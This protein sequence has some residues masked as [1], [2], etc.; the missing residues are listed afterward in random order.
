MIRFG[1]IVGEAP[2]VALEVIVIHGV[3]AEQG[4]E[5]ADVGFGQARP[6]QVALCGEARFVAAQRG[7]ALS[8][9]GFVETRDYVCAA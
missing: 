6:A 5:L 2:N 8:R 7:A 4:R 1:L 3:E 9:M